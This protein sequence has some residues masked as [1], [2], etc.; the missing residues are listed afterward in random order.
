LRPALSS[1]AMCMQCLATASVTVGA[2][3]GVR[4]WLSAKGGAWLTPP[5]MRAITISLLA[6]AVLAAGVGLGGSG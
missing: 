3:S 4:A 6:L 1:G 5:R 2:A